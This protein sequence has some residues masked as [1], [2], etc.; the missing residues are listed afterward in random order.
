VPPPLETELTV[1]DGE[2]HAGDTL[3]ATLAPAAGE[4]TAVEPVGLDT[5]VAAARS[6]PG[7]AHHPF[8]TCFV[9]GP[10]HP[11]GLRIFPGLLPDGRT[12]APWIVPA[13]VEF[14]TVW[15]ALD[16]PG[17]WCALAGG[18]VYV[19]GRIAATVAELPKPGDTCVVAGALEASS[20][21]KAMVNST[22]YAPSGARIASAR[23]TWIAPN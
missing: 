15:A 10:D 1:A 17:G 22:V 13:D 6:Y 7:L 8:P 3:V 2:V 5:A 19:L 16:C 14:A 21:R 4:L 11:D 9:C 12:A 20:G 18:R 23:A